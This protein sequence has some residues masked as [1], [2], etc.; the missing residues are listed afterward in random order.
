MHDQSIGVVIPT[1][2]GGK[3]WEEVVLS[4]N[5]QCNFIN[6]ILVIDSGSTDSTLQISQSSGLNIIKISSKEFNHGGTRNFGLK[7]INCDIVIFI[8]QDAILNPFAIQNIIKAFDNIDVAV[9]YGKQISHENANP[10]AKHAR[11]FNYK[12]DS[13]V[14]SKDDKTRYGIK[15]VFT[16]NSFAAYR[17]KYFKELGGFPENTIFA[18]DMY[19]TSKALL[20]GYKVAYVSDAIVKHS[21]NYSIIEEFKRSFDIGVFHHTEKWILKYY[22]QP[23]G[24]GFRF[25]KSELKYLMSEKKICWIPI[26]F[27]NNIMKFVG[28]KLGINYTKLPIKAIKYFSMHKKYWD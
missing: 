16:S 15:T 18:E 20:K 5:N 2:N 11:I 17:V 12:N 1:Y 14:Y 23:G 19:F 21:H 9:A 10:L 8:T 13:Y 6:K 26:A 28:Y 24:E 27:I 7:E 4:L 3:L 25:V 22:G